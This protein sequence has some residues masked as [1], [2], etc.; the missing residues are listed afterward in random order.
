[1]NRVF[2]VIE[3]DKILNKLSSYTTSQKVLNRISEMKMLPLDEAK[4]AQRRRHT[5]QIPI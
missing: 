1:M 3:F 2:K 4:N 5:K